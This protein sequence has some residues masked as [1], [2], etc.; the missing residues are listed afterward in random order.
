MKIN[1]LLILNSEFIRMSPFRIQNSQFT[2]QKR[3][4]NVSSTWLRV[5]VTLVA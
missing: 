4:P 1:H 2:I 5:L 3:T